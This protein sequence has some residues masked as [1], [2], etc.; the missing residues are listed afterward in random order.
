MASK[1]AATATRKQS[2]T[3][4]TQQ[5]NHSFASSIWLLFAVLHAKAA[6]V[7]SRHT[8]RGLWP[9]QQ[10]DNKTTAQHH[11]HALVSSI[12]LLPA[13]VLHTAAVPSSQCTW[14]H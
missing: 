6:T 14:Q 4:T 11:S 9:A 2:N 3:A 13:A 1:T 12:W 8:H 7:V 5:Q 10:R